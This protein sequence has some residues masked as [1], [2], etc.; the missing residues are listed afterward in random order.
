MTY[1]ASGILKKNVFVKLRVHYIV[2]IWGK[3]ICSHPQTS[4]YQVSDLLLRCYNIRCS[5]ANDTHIK[6][7]IKNK[8]DLMVCQVCCE[9]H[10]QWFQVV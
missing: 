8:V 6:N 10:T 2:C 7:N 9:S 5:T 4:Y 1:L 3:I